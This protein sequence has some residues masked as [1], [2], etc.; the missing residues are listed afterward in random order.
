MQQGVTIADRS[1]YIE[2][3]VT[4]GKRYHHS[5]VLLS[6]GT[7]SIGG[8]VTVGPHVVIRNSVVADGVTIDAFTVLDGARAEEGVRMGPFSRLRPKAHLKK[9]VH[10]GNFVEVKNSV[11][12]EG[13]KAN[14]LTYIGDAEVG[15][16]V[17]IGAGTITC[18]YDARTSTRRP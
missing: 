11:I 1:V 13:S 12:E 6:H 2:S 17:N 16:A 15:R 9:N 7:T 8:D 3:D 4:I 10:I 14:H 5:A 18:N